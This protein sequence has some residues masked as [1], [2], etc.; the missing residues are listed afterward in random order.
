M[1]YFFLFYLFI[2]TIKVEIYDKVEMM[3]GK[4]SRIFTESIT[5]L[6]TTEVG[7]A[8]YH[9]GQSNTYIYAEY[10]I[11]IHLF[12]HSYITNLNEHLNRLQLK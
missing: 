2:L 4:T 1:I 10:Y 8:K 11:R 12:I 9:V 5:H 6:I 3:M 7:S